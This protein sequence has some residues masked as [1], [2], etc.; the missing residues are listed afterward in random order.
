MKKLLMLSL[1]ISLSAGAQ[2]LESHISDSVKPLGKLLEGKKGKVVLGTFKSSKATDTC[3]P[4]KGVNTKISAALSRLGIKTT[5][6][7]RMVNIDADQAE[8]SRV[9]KLSG[10]SYIILGSYEVTGTKFKLDCTLYDHNGAGVG[11]CDEVAASAISQE[12]ADN[13]NCPKED[14][15]APVVTPLPQS[16]AEGPSASGDPQVKKVDDYICSVI[17]KDYD[18]KRLVTA[19]YE[20]KFYTLEELKGIRKDTVEDALDVK[21]DYCV[22]LGNFVL[23][24]DYWQ[25][26]GAQ[27]FL[28]DTTALGASKILSWKHPNKSQVKEATRCLKKDNNWW[29]P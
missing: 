24:S 7:A 8:I 14:K 17:H 19:L 26:S 23:C 9:T 20:K 13:I 11:A 10:G 22:T 18:L 29:N 15:P 27:A 1:F 12:A 4:N 16:D 5:L 21:K 25:G 6:A 2:S 28:G 3:A